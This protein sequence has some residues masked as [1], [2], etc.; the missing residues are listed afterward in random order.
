MGLESHCVM[1]AQTLINY[2]LIHFISDVQRVAVECATPTIQRVTFGALS[3]RK[4]G[5]KEVLHKK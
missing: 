5:K 4:E 1:V 2:S 3:S